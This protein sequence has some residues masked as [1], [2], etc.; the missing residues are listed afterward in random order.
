MSSGDAHNLGHL[1]SVIREDDGLWQAALDR[2]IV[3]V[4]QEVLGFVQDPSAAYD[5]AK[6]AD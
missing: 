3:L 6:V 5:A 1:G 4:D 2:R